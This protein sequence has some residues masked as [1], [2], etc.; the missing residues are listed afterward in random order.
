IVIF[1]GTFPSGQYAVT[2]AGKGFADLYVDGSGDAALTGPSPAFFSEAVREATITLPAS[3]ATVIS[4]GCTVDNASWT[5]INLQKV[6]IR[7][8][9]LDPYGGLPQ[10][11]PRVA[12]VGGEV[13]YFSSAGPTLTGVPKPD[14]LAPGAVVIGAMSQQAKPGSPN[15]IFTTQCPPKK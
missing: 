14:I 10:N 6:G 3:N 13:C 1:T 4:V 11:V 15:S 12:P 9:K 5:S 2:L 8:P 7:E